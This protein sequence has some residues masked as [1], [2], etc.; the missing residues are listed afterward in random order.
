M[1]AYCDFYEVA[2]PDERLLWLSR[3]LLASPEHAGVQ[4][5][6]R[7]EDRRPAGFATVY[8]T[9]QTLSA[10]RVGVMNDLFVGDAARGTGL[11]DALI[12]RC[13]EQTRARGGTHLVWQTAK[14]NHRAQSVY[15]R[16]GAQRAEWYD[17]EVEL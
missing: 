15:A 6:A 8:W 3:E 1:R 5:L 17:Y 14:D 10:S 16:V 7:G 4:L 12:R 2:P 11:A 9:F 13:A